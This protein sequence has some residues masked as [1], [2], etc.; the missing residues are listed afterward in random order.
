M[1][2]KS[3]LE[4]VRKVNQIILDSTAQGL[5]IEPAADILAG[6]INGNL[7]L[8][9]DN[10]KLLSDISNQ[11]FACQRLQDYLVAEAVL[12][13]YYNLPALLKSDEP[14]VNESYRLEKC[15]LDGE[16]KSACAHGEI[17]IILMPVFSGTGPPGI[18]MAH[19][20]QKPF[21]YD[22]LIL[23]EL[24]VSIIGMIL[25]HREAMVLEEER[26]SRTMVEVAFESL[27]YSEV[28]AIEEIFKKLTQKE[29]IIIA[30]K[31]ADDL[32]ITRSVIVNALRKF[33]SA[34]VIESRSL[35]MKGT[36]IQLKNPYALEEIAARSARLRAAFS[37]KR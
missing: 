2:E 34:G 32:G 27:S 28:E 24:G 13:D 33:E 8:I 36:Y 16:G 25:M 35:G 11:Q 18:I 15:P 4:K 37:E 14:R 21:E 20:C 26:W 6:T 22:D 19:R 5:D 10:G 29:N 1:L 7:F 12:P 9:D 17:H 31:I 3:L 30:S 23:A